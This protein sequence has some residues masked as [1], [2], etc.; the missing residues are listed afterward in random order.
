MSD[1]APGSVTQ[2]LG[3]AKQGDAEAKRELWER[4]VKLLY[5]MARDGTDDDHR[6]GTA[7]TSDVVHEVAVR[8]L[9]ADLDKIADRKHFQNWLRQVVRGKRIDLIRRESARPA[10]ALG[11]DS[12]AAP[13]DEHV[14]FLNAEM[15][16]LLE[17][18]PLT[19]YDT[20]LTYL[21]CGNEREA[22]ERL[23]ISR[24]ELRHRLEQIGTALKRHLG[25]DD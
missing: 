16:D 24:H 2:M 19:L 5:A 6:S 10:G 1:S 21:E 15:N 18:L 23:G 7:D 4:Y 14:G 12:A 8:F 17:S 13:A 3:R 20:A 25:G 9:A 22:A 11:D